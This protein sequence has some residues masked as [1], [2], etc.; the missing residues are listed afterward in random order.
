MA[1]LSAGAMLQRRYEVIGPLGRGGS[2][3]AYRVR[4]RLFETEVALKLVHG[5]DPRLTRAL[6]DEFARLA[7]L[8]H[9]HLA[10]LF[11]LGA[12]EGQ[13]FYTAALI[14]GRPLCEGDA[15]TDEASRRRAL[16]GALRALAFLHALGLRHGDV[17]ASNIVV[18]PDGR[19]V[20][21]DLGC[22]RPFGPGIEGQVSGT[23]GYIAPELLEARAA[24]ARADLY[25]V[26][27]T[28]RRVLPRALSDDV[29]LARFV[30]ELT[31]ADPS[32]RP[33][34]VGAVLEALG[35][36]A[37]LAIAWPRA[38]RL[39]GREAELERFDASHHM[40]RAR[41]TGPR[42]LAIRGPDGI[43]KSHLARELKWRAQLDATALEGDARSPRAVRALLA[44]ASGREVRNVEDVALAV[45]ELAEGPPIWL[46]LDDA[47]RL[48]AEEA[49]ALAQVVRCIPADGALG[50][51]V[52]ERSAT[53]A[54]G[55]VL[56]LG[57]LEPAAVEEWAG[58]ALRAEL[59]DEAFRAT[60]GHP[61]HVARLLADASGAVE[62]AHLTALARRREP[63]VEKQIGSVQGPLRRALGLVA[64][65]G[66]LDDELAARLAITED[67]SA[68]LVTAGWLA[69]APSGLRLA[70]PA[71]GPSIVR[72]MGSEPLHATLADALGDGPARTYHLAMAGRVEDA[73]RAFGERLDRVRAAPSLF[74]HAA[75]ALAPIAREP[76]TWVAAIEVVLDAEGPGE[77]RALIAARLR[78]RPDAEDRVALRT[79]A[80]KCYLRSGDG[81]RAL[82]LAR[83]AGDGLGA[84]DARSRA[85]RQLGDARSALATALH[86]LSRADGAPP[87]V[88]GALHE[89]AGIAASLLGELDEAQPHLTEAERLVT[90]PRARVRV[91]SY[92]SIH[93]LRRGDVDEAVARSERALHL[94]E[95]H[96]FA[97]QIAS[98]CANLG[99]ARQQR[100]EWGV[101][102]DAYARALRLAV[103]LGKRSS[104]LAARFNVA[105]L[106]AAIGLFARARGA[107]DDLEGR[108]GGAA[109][110]GAIALVRA[111]IALAERDD[112][113]CEDA[114]GR[115]R[116]AFDAADTA[117]ERAE[118]SLL[119][120]RHALDRGELDTALAVLSRRWPA[121]IESSELGD[122]RASVRAALELARGDLAAAL[123]IASAPL[124]DR[125]PAPIVAERATIEAR[126]H[127]ARG[128]AP[129]TERAEER[130]RRAWAAIAD[131]L[132]V[133]LRGA[134]ERHPDRRGLRAAKPIEPAPVRVAP[135]GLH[136]LVEINRRLNAELD[137]DA[138]LE[139][140]LDA[141]IAST[142][143]ERG[144]VL[145]PSPSEGFRVA[146]ARRLT[147]AQLADDTHAFS[148]SIAERVV[149]GDAP[150]LATDAFAD[151]RFA[152]EASVHAMRLRSVLCLSIRA[153]ERI[154]GALYLDHRLLAGQFCADDLGLLAAFADQVG[155]ALRNARQREALYRRTAE[156]ERRTAELE[157]AQRRAELHV[158]E[159]ALE[160]ERLEGAL[161]ASR[162]S[163]ELRYAYDAIVG[164]SAPM[165]SLLAQ[166]DRLVE[167]PA[168]VL[169]RGESG[170]G[171]E[172]VARALHFNGP[173]K[174]RGFVAV[175]CAAIPES[176]LEAELFGHVAGAFTS[177]D[178]ERVGLLSRADGG[179]LFLDEIAELPLSMQ[180]KLLRV[181]QER[182]VR[183]VG[184]SE[185]IEVDFRLVAATHRDLR[186]LVEAGRFREDLYYR[187]AVVELT[188]PPLRERVQDVPL[189][190]RHVLDGLA[191]AE[192]REPPRVARSALE[193]LTRHPWP[194]NVRELVNVMTRAYVL[195]AQDR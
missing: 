65:G 192:G 163:L 127:D 46:V 177:A 90:D 48:D 29:Q 97:D 139:H 112:E 44:A 164:R 47:D 31:R 142:G 169:V 144:F 64:A 56:A 121:A 60:G 134:F 124:S 110:G 94:A 155:I 178:R 40:L 66:G 137:A 15:E 88:R 38:P 183:P 30:D 185:E 182:R 98:A 25:A 16:I 149:A 162:Q 143:A 35:D 71:E 104:E 136:W 108:D 148:R 33:G 130:A 171:K 105:N 114:I 189:L 157:S 32:E 67:D 109:Y 28:L 73:E 113:A 131:T 96:G 69:R 87:T 120:A 150:V 27:V 165:R 83:R 95:E 55:V 159:Q 6:R 62:R 78:A 174:E 116:V 34:D 61:A 11:D 126:I 195:G 135:G 154:E 24:D 100:G 147:A 111:E 141:A 117:R 118:L 54:A 82:Q 160:I 138:V 12:H 58:P 52:T 10:Q 43:G 180:A 86:A 14:D 2:A 161:A 63:S 72:A 93:A 49:D 168:S 41:M 68:A 172:L 152:T 151:P 80:A 99:A 102:L 57:P 91:A 191:R 45:D 133:A 194:G 3:A 125:S 146:C 129:A 5:D 140:A 17:K 4:D 76:A 156:L 122:R 175:S 37:P 21:L 81:R 123:A 1:W 184:A 166:V 181:L 188:V 36:R 75:R 39:V 13:L 42:V 145:V 50:V 77:A 7:R 101:A 107:L 26:G 59:R 51:A 158:A 103:A 74:R 19:G 89:D 132:P 85:E 119:E 190:V 23:P 173:R 84:A 70:R 20:L 153:G 53:V 187:V 170:T 22:A 8:A 115:A 106:H 9:P 92:L 167:S 186:A 179:T 193:R 128:D 176:L 18:A 79:L